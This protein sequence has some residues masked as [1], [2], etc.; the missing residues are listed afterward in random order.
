MLENSIFSY[1]LQGWWSKLPAGHLYSTQIWVPPPTCIMKR[2][3]LFDNRQVNQRKNSLKNKAFTKT[4]PTSKV[5]QWFSNKTGAIGKP[6]RSKSERHGRVASPICQEGQSERTFQIFPLFPDFS[7]IFLNFFPLFDGI[8]AVKGALCPPDPPVA[9][10]LKA[11]LSRPHI[12][13][14]TFPLMYPCLGMFGGGLK[15]ASLLDFLLK[16]YVELLSI[17]KTKIEL[18]LSSR[19]KFWQ[20]LLFFVSWEPERT[21]TIHESVLTLD[22]FPNHAPSMIFKHST[23][24]VTVTNSLRN[25]HGTFSLELP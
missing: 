18:Q 8:F 6:E 9:T 17:L 22:T 20:Y 24:T 16:V 10:P 2:K 25:L 19:A 4:R 11:P 1:L 14:P 5:N 13:I 21:T 12:R 23:G 15:I 7:P 3:I